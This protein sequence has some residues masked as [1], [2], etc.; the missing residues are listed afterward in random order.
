MCLVV[1]FNIHQTTLFLKKFSIRYPCHLIFFMLVALLHMLHLSHHNHGWPKLSHR[2]QTPKQG[3]TRSAPDKQ[4]APVV[5]VDNTDDNGGNPS[6]FSK[7]DAGGSRAGRRMIWTFDETMRLV[8]YLCTSIQSYN[9]LLIFIHH[10]YY[11]STFTKLS[12][13]NAGQCLLEK[14]KRSN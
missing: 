12:I 1:T 13:Y 2:I 3:T 14:L 4:T 7:K 8:S 6:I 5:D 11:A 9:C 10:L